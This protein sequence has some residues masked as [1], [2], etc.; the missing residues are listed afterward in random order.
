MPV[1]T[2]VVWVSVS[3]M[4]LTDTVLVVVVGWSRSQSATMALAP[5]CH[6]KAIFGVPMHLERWWK[7]SGW[8]G[9]L[10]VCYG[11]MVSLY[12]DYDYESIPCVILAV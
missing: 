8:N 5:R 12:R 9:V 1:V 4:V 6:G 2:V 7:H 3:V 10:G 11:N